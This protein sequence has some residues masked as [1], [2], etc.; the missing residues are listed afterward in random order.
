MH[1]KKKRVRVCR[2]VRPNRKADLVTTVAGPS[3]AAVGSNVSYT[4]TVTNLGPGT[5]LRAGVGVEIG[6]FPITVP[7]KF[8]PGPVSGEIS[9]GRRCSETEVGDREVNFACP[10]GSLSLARGASIQVTV[11]L[12]I[13]RIAGRLLYVDTE[14]YATSRDP[15]SR[16]NEAIANAQTTGCD[17]SYPGDLCIAP[18]PPD[19]NCDDLAPVTDI[20]VDWSVADPDPHHFDGDH[21]G[22]GCEP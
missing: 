20:D 13:G 15:Q 6:W 16:N 17:P 2:K 9:G 11:T 8:L 1:A 12:Q 21:D 10:A 22:I 18:P 5:A 7:G 3:T 14:A 4:V 19:L